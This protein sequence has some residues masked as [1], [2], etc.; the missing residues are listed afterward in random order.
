MKIFRTLRGVISGT[1]SDEPDYFAYGATLRIFGDA[2]DF[3]QIS[4]T[5]GV[6]ATRSHRKGDRK[7]DGALGFGHDMWAY[8]PSVPEDRPLA[9]HIE[10][11]WSQ[12]RPAE[13]YL[14]DLKRVATVDVFLGYR[15]NIDHAG[16]EVPHTALEM[17]VRLE[18]PLG[19][20]IIIA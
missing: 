15:S 9:E 18:I 5:L 17:F 7:R 14:R 8:Q 19:V 10:S 3:D 1:E 16:F 2:L 4:R 13:A 20:S 11:L 12:I 6:N